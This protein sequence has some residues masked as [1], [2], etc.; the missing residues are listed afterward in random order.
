MEQDKS[1]PQHD[2]GTA[3]FTFGF[4]SLWFFLP[5]AVVALFFATIKTALIVGGICFAV[6][7][8]V[9]HALAADLS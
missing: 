2:W 8:V 6:V 9:M 1:T 5:F 4:L 7:F 3:I